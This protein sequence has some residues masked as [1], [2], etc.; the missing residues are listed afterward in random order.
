VGILN[1][2][3][4]LVGPLP[5]IVN[6][7]QFPKII[8]CLTKERLSPASGYLATAQA[9]LAAVTDEIERTTK[10]I[11]DKTSSIE[12]NFRAELGMPIECDK[13]REK[14]TCDGGDQGDKK[15]PDQR[16]S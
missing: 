12:A 6:P 3:Q 11:A 8:C 13:Y 15:Q 4:R 9:N 2:R 10:Q 1:L 16:A 7:I 5:Y 14:E